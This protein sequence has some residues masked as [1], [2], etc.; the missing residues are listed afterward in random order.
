[1]HSAILLNPNQSSRYTVIGVASFGSSR[2]CGSGHP[3]FA[4]ITPKVK[5]WIMSNSWGS[6]DSSLFSVLKTGLMI[7]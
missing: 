2:N 7:F 4:R 5:S 3:G 1:M 6:Q